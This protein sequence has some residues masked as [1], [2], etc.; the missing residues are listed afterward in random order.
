MKTYSRKSWSDSTLPV[1]RDRQLVLG[2]PMVSLEQ[3]AKRIGAEFTQIG[4][5]LR[6]YL[7]FFTSTEVSILASNL[8]RQKRSKVSLNTL[9]SIGLN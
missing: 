4:C 9:S 7:F 2:T 8:L 3:A 6:L 1:D 5:Q